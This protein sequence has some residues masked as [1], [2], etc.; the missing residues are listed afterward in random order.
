MSDDTVSI[1]VT[2]PKDADTGFLC[3]GCLCPVDP[4]TCCCGSDREDHRW[5]NC[6]FRPFRCQC[7]VYEDPVYED[8]VLQDLADAWESCEERARVVGEV[9]DATPRGLF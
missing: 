1:A 4:Y 6:V 3:T 2:I 5:N 7:P 9:G 8:P